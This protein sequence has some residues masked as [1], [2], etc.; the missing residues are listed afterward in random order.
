MGCYDGA[1]L[2]ELV[3]S[4][5]L[6]K[7]ASIV[8]KSDIGLYRDD[9]LGI[10]YNVL[11]PEIERKKKAIVKVFK[12]CSLTITI[13]W[14]FKTVD[15]VDVTFDLDNNA[16]KPFRKENNKPTYINK[17]SNYS[18]SI[19]KQLPKSTE[20]R[21]SETSSNKTIFDE[22]IKPYKD[23]YEASGFSEALNYVAPTTNKNK[24]IESGK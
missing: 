13:M 5:I 9:G 15:F 6:N 16:Y 1:E 20:K 23:A 12:G 8:N 4:F 3:G 17:H 18:P 22:S 10:F 7:L 2:G 14:N 24:K 19:P 11:K 21:I